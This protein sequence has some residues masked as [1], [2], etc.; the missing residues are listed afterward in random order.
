MSIKFTQNILNRLIDGKPL[1]PIDDTEDVWNEC[2]WSSDVECKTY[3]CKRMFSLFK[4]VYLDGTTEYHDHDRF[5]CV[6][7]DDPEKSYRSGFI[8]AL[9]HEHFPI[10]MPYN[11][12]SKPYEVYVSECL[13]DPDN[14]SFDTIGILYVIKPDGE[15]EVIDRFFK[16]A[17]VSYEEISKQEYLERIEASKSNDR[18]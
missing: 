13:V 12:S 2:T 1:T 7:S 10:T 8:S 14:G 18:L 6:D 9:M 5:V 15:K 16:E 11:P 17:V 4:D 3:Q